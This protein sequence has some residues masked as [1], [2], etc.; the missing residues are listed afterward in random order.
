MEKK[1]NL[2]CVSGYWKIKNKHDNSFDNWFDNTLKI[3][4]PYIFF[5]NKESIEMVKK[6]R[7]ELPTYYI[8]LEIENFHTYK[9][10]DKMITHPFHCPSVELN[11]IWNEKIFLLEQALKENPYSTDYFCWIDAGICVYREIKPPND[12]FPNIKKFSIMPKDRLIYSASTDY[13][14]SLVKKSNYYHHVCGTSYILHK[15]IIPTFVKLYETYMDKLVDKNNL[16]SDQL[17]LTHIFKDN[18]N[19]FFKIA[20]GYGEIIPKLY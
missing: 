14:K 17:I 6:F 12:P 7:G 11:L 13:N 8:E 10:Y 15:N 9:Y 4:C 2:T 1:Y 20:N 18:E 19:L 3:N 16:W 5:G